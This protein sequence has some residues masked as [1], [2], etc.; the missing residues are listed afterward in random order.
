METMFNRRQLIQLGAA[1]GASCVLCSRFPLFAAGP[2]PTGIISPG[3]R[4]SKVKVARLY[5]GNSGGQYG[6]LWPK[7]NLDLK[8]EIKFYEGHFKKLKDQISDVDFV[9]D[10]LVTTPDQVKKIKDK[11]E[12]ID[13]ILV[14]HLTLGTGGILNEIYALAKPTMIFS[15]PY[16]GHEWSSF[17]QVFKEERGAK[18]DAILTTDYSQLAAAIRPFRAIHH[19]RQ[20]K[21]CNLSTRDVS[22]YAQSMKEKFGTEI[23]NIELDRMLKIYKSVSDSAAKAECDEWMK[24]A[25][26]VVEPDKDEVFRSCKLALAFEKLLEE[27]D[28]T[29]MTVDCYGSMYQKLPAFPCIGFTRLNDIGLGG[30]CESDLRCAMT[31][32]IMQGLCGKPGFISDPTVDE[33]QNSIILAHCLGTRMMDGPDGPM[34]PYKI[35]TIMERQE[36]A[37]PQVEM[38]LGQKVTQALLVGDDTIIYFTGDIIDTPVALE[39]DRGCRTKIDVKVDGDVRTLWKNWSNGLHRQTCY[40][41][42][43][44]DLERFCR[45]TDIKLVDES[46]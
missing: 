10:E 3:C 13:G 16:S 35:R 2:G 31:H 19:L 36:G 30:I 24:K 44:K 26:A 37:V 29:V 28:A 11:I 12:G 42:I 23:K 46:A 25:D 18:V 1:C 8:K 32:I 34:A 15:A 14:I 9:V 38:R 41:D 6:G 27:E 39:D 33:S 17:G 7:P 21:I 20:A 40:G 45:F 5:V 22:T 4:R 43:T